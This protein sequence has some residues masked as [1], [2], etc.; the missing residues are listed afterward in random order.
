[1]ADPRE[2]DPVRALSRA[3]EL[4]RENARAGVAEPVQVVVAPREAEARAEPTF[5]GCPECGAPVGHDHGCARPGKVR[6]A[7]AAFVAS[8]GMGV[9]TDG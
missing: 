3:H 2:V 1:V 6:L 7:E 5:A 9:R 4:A 8:G